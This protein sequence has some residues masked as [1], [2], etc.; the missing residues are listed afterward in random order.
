MKLSPATKPRYDVSITLTCSLC[1]SAGAHDKDCYG[2]LLCVA[3]REACSSC[4]RDPAN[5]QNDSGPA[6]FQICASI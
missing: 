1:R 2:V 4:T 3:P 5:K 6:L